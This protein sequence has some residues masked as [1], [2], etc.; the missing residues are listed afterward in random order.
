MAS[1]REKSYAE[2]ALMKK[3]NNKLALEYKKKWTKPTDTILQR[4][5]EFV[6]L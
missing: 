1:E 6:S 5:D 3:Q 2:M 4:G